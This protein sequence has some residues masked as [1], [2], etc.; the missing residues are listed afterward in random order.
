[1]ERLIALASAFHLPLRLQPIPERSALSELP[2]EVRP[3]FFCIEA[4]QQDQPG[5][6]LYVD[7][8]TLCV[9]GCP[10]WR[11]YRSMTRHPWRPLPMGARCTIDH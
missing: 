11:R 8:D 4:L 1:M 10:R 9:H 7:A 6:Y 3:Y 2:D 5:R